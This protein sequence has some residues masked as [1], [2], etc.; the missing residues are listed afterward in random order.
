MKRVTGLH[1]DHGRMETPADQRQITEKIQGLV[2]GQFIHET[3][4][5][6]RARRS[7]HHR[8]LQTSTTAEPCGADGGNPVFEAERARGSEFPQE[9]MERRTALRL[10][11]PHV[12]KK[13]HGVAPRGAA[14][15]HHFQRAMRSLQRVA[16]ALRTRVGP[17]EVNAGRDGQVVAGDGRDDPVLV[18]DPNRSREPDVVRFGV[19]FPDTGAE[20]TFSERKRAPIQGGRFHAIHGDFGVVDAQCIESRQQVLHGVDADSLSGK[21]GTTG[22]FTHEIRRRRDTNS[23]DD[24]RDSCVRLCRSHSYAAEITSVQPNSLEGCR[25]DQRLLARGEQGT[26]T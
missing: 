21:G 3:K 24:E 14:A 2:A 5:G 4:R 11:L 15:S 20:K 16:K 12:R 10:G 13:R 22:R 17:V 8:I 23:P 1:G 7:E 9:Q 6:A 26:V 19:L 18:L 25:L